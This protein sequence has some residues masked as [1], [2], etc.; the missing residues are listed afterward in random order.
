LATLRI[1]MPALE[2]ADL[3]ALMRRWRDEKPYDPRAGLSA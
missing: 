2:D 1:A 3:A